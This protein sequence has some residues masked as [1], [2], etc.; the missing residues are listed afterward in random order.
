[1]RNLAEI[2][3]KLIEKDAK[4][5]Y[6]T[7]G[8]GSLNRYEIALKLFNTFNGAPQNYYFKNL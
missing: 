5:I 3:L 7:V 8:D 4:G 2:I 1:M 6:H